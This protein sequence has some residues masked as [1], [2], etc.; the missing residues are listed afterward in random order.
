MV[1]TSRSAYAKAYEGWARTG[2]TAAFAVER[3][4]ELLGQ[5]LKDIVA[6]PTS[7]ATQKQAEGL[8]IAGDA[9]LCRSSTSRSTAPT[10]STRPTW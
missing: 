3:V 4:G 2:S 6:I 9:R 5:A 1:G 7:V 8:G 10:R